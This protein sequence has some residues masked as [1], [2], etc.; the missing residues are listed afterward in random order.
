MSRQAIE[1]ILKGL[2]TEAG[3]TTHKQLARVCARLVR[4]PL[5]QLRN[6]ALLLVG[7]YAALRR[8]NLVGLDFVDLTYV[9]LTYVDDD[10]RVDLRSSKTD[11]ERNGAEVW[12]PTSLDPRVPCPV[13][14]FTAYEQAFTARL[15]TND[16]GSY[17]VF[18]P[19]DRHG[20]IVTGPDGRP[21]GY[22]RSF[23]ERCPTDA[24]RRGMRKS[25]DGT[26]IP[27]WPRKR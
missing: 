2:R 23:F 27:L 22:G 14:A 11:Q 19:I 4:K 12:L 5:A 3:G 21:A 18:T 13:A 17:P 15:G 25:Y 16:I 20:G 10:I 24:S 8:S 9:D 26:V 7:W 1:H 6:E